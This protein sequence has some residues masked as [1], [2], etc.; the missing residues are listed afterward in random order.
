MTGQEV[1][2]VVWAVVWGIVV[3]MIAWSIFCD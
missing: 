1:V 3:L 2:D